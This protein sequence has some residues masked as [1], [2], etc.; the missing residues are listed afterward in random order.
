MRPFD[1]HELKRSGGD[2]VFLQ[3]LFILRIYIE[4][5]S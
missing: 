4:M 3:P 5:D 1:F 2:D